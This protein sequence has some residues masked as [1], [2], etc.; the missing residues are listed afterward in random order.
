MSFFYCFLNYV[1]SIFPPKQHMSAPKPHQNRPYN[2]HPQYGSPQQPSSLGTPHVG[3]PFQRGSSNTSSHEGRH[4]WRYQ[5]AAQQQGPSN[6]ALVPT[7][8]LLK[9][10]AKECKPFPP[11]CVG[12]SVPHSLN[13]ELFLFAQFLQP[14]EA[15]QQRN[16]FLVNIVVSFLS[17]VWPSVVLH[18]M[19]LSAAGVYPPKD[20]A[21]HFYSTGTETDESK[22]KEVQEQLRNAAVTCGFQLE[23]FMDIRD[24]FAMMCTESRFGDRIVVR[25]GAR[26]EQAKKSAEALAIRVAQVAPVRVTLCAVDALLRQN[27]VVDD[28]VSNTTGLSSEAVAIML[29]SIANSYSSDDVPDAERLLMD[30][31]LTYG[32]QTHFDCATQSV[33]SSG[34]ATPLAKVHRDAALSVL[35]FD[36][37]SKVNLAAKVEKVPHML[38]VF[39][40][41][42]TALSQFV[43]VHPSQRRAQSPL[44]TI[45]GGEAF[46]SRVLQLYHQQVTPF[47]Q[48]V[49]EKAS[50]LAQLR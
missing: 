27:K 12:K 13:E 8:P 18:Q 38:A 19:G 49:A 41:C 6:I 20:A 45:I 9:A 15:E 40:Y 16:Q 21:V 47:Y 14:T 23:F 30:F 3:V 31:F 1:Y 32:F 28:S 29:L 43:Q 50:L 24:C 5:T 44:S 35:D 46:W 42:Y 34:M 22:L 17:S 33:T 2:V 4:S 11:W 39:N 37:D 48:I 36:D 25:Y 10:L 26:A 7:R